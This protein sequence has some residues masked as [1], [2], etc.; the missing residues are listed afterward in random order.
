MGL[1]LFF[2]GSLGW[3]GEGRRAAVRLLEA[4][5][6]RGTATR[7]F[8][9]M[10]LDSADTQ[11][12]T[13]SWQSLLNAPL[14]CQTARVLGCAEVG[15][16]TELDLIFRHLRSTTVHYCTDVCSVRACV[17]AGTCTASYTVRTTPAIVFLMRLCFNQAKVDPTTIDLRGFGPGAA[18]ATV[19]AVLRRLR[20]LMR[21]Q[22]VG[23]LEL[24]HMPESLKQMPKPRVTPVDGDGVPAP[25]LI[26][27][28]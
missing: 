9:D 24:N 6:R 8:C 1:Y 5:I 7:A 10:I 11:P 20:E 26:G 17:L 12:A 13:G 25:F 19:R 22:A 28:L 21:R 14:T 18:V 23:S 2:L 4:E 15:D 16:W 3:G 27:T